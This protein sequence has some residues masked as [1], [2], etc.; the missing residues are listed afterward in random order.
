MRL[1]IR[2][3]SARLAFT[4]IELLVVIAIIAVL[5]GLLLPAVQKVREAA[6]RAKCQNNLE[7]IALACHHAHDQHGYMPPGL[8][9]FAKTASNRGG[10]G[11]IL[12][13]LLPYLEQNNLYAAS[14]VNGVFDATQNNVYAKPVLNYVCPSDPSAGDGVVKD[15]I[16]TLW[17]ASSYAGNAQVFCKT[18]SDG[19]LEDPQLYPQLNSTFADGASNTLL[20]VEKYAR[21]TNATY[22]DGGCFWA[23]A[24]ANLTVKP[25]HPGFLLSWN[26]YSVGPG[27]KFK[28]QPTP[29]RGNCD[30]TLSSTPHQS[31][32]AVLADGSVRTISPSISG[33][34]WWAACTPNG[35]ESLP[36]DW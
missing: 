15:S 17:G 9:W 23:Y 34:T 16:G 6:A 29:F 14:G 19:Y 21:C 25:L 24:V 28:V 3:D 26:A 27:S 18:D 32:N 12:F 20:F 11:V 33:D 13:L 31:M 22:V 1:R 8:G 2:S 5:I 4:L 10:K 30:P 7:Q 36:A 35:G